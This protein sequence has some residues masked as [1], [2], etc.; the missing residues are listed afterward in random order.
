[1]FTQTL[2]NVAV[3]VSFSL[4]SGHGIDLALHAGRKPAAKAAEKVV[5]RETTLS[6]KLGLG[7]ESVARRDNEIAALQSSARS[8]QSAFTLGKRI[9]KETPRKLAVAEQ[10]KGKF[11]LIWDGNKGVY[12][13]GT[14]FPASHKRNFC[15]TPMCMRKVQSSAFRIYL[16]SRSSAFSCRQP[17]V[18]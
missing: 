5:L 3:L 15:S 7:V 2:I 16:W 1:M 11:V 14:Y 17:N 10:W 9:K 13:D 4:S 8:F 12:F 18:A 6:E